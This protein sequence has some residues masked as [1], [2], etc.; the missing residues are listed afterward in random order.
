MA[1]SH[2]RRKFTK[3]SLQ[4][5]T[6]GRRARSFQPRTREFP[7]TVTKTKERSVATSFLRLW[8]FH[9]LRSPAYRTKR[10]GPPANDPLLPDSVRQHFRKCLAPTG[11]EFLCARMAVLYVDQFAVFCGGTMYSTISL[12]DSEKTSVARYAPFILC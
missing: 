2:E 6:L 3:K 5:F 11:Q 12:S 10:N 1:F 9:R 7:H 4:K 8:L